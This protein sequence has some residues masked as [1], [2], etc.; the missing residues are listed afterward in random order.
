[1]TLN[2]RIFF[3]EGIMFSWGFGGEEA[4]KILLL[5]NL[6]S[7]Y[8]FLHIIFKAKIEFQKGLVDTKKCRA[9]LLYLKEQR[10]DVTCEFKLLASL[11][12]SLQ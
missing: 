8:N 9:S 10:V 4:A 5:I 1:M 6:R 12:H 2:P 7:T 11:V 3:P